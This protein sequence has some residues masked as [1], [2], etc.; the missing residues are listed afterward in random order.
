M[1]RK[2]KL[3]FS[4]R[5]LLVMSSFAIIFLLCFLI[6]VMK[7]LNNAWQAIGDSAQIMKLQEDKIRDLQLL[8]IKIISK[9]A[10]I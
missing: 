7:D 1:E 3:K 6:F 10:S 4:D 8:V 5:L 9:G 2:N